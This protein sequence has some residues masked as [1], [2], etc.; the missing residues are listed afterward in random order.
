LTDD[1]VQLSHV[2]FAYN[3][4]PV[5]NDV[6]LRLKQ[7]ERLGLLG[8][9][10][11]GKTTLLKIALGL[12]TG[13]SGEA[14]VFGRDPTEARRAGLVGYVAQRCEAELAFPLSVRQ[15]VALPLRR[16]GA[17]R[18]DA[19]AKSQRM[20]DLVGAGDIAR[21]PIGQISGGQLQRVLIARALVVEPKLLALDEPTVGIDVAGQQAFADLLSRLHVELGLTLL[22]VSHDVRAIAA[23]SD[24]VACLS[25]TLHFHDAPSG[26]TPQV[27]AEVFRHDVSAVF[28]DVHVNAHR[29]AECPLS[30]G[31]EEVDPAHVPTQ[32]AG[33]DDAPR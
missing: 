10:G 5:L 32:P 33:G 16:R 17:K 3:G 23:A 29:A 1:A 11:G 15:V 4:K 9:N 18:N 28:G 14:R 25:K 6:S 30:G 31:A 20:L 8:P 22:V 13:Y 24:K 26:L 2:S 12:L 21:Q 19:D 27:L 7:G